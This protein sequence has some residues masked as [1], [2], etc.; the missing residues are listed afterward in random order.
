[1]VG[2]ARG[3]LWSLLVLKP[4]GNVGSVGFLLVALGLVLLGLVLLGLVTLDLVAL[5]FGLL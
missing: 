5:D 1:M 4:R 3:S 2:A